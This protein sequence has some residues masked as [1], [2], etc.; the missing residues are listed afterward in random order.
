MTLRSGGIYDIGL[1]PGY[2]KTKRRLQGSRIVRTKH[3]RLFC[4]SDDE[5]EEG[6][7]IL[8]QLPAQW[9]IS[10][11]Q[12]GGF[13]I[14]EQSAE[15][16]PQ[17]RTRWIIDLTGDDQMTD[18]EKED[19]DKPP[20]QR[21][22][23]WSWDFETEEIAMTKDVDGEDVVNSVFDPIEVT[24]PVIIPVLTIERQ[25]N[26]FDPDTIL[27]Y[28]NHVNDATFWGA[29]AGSVLCAG[30][31]ERKGETFNGVEYRAVS[32]VFK[33]RIPNITDVIEG[34][35]L[36]LLDHGPN[37]INQSTGDKEAFTDAEGRK[38]TTNLDASGLP[39]DP[40]D[41]PHILRFKQFKEADFGSLNL[42]WPL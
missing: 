15:R 38:I 28:V 3:W 17:K 31:R 37:A 12:G 13:A 8:G 40:G 1:A 26:G 10:A 9:D 7:D 25:E 34:W 35:K 18:Q 20:D 4:H 42:D 24:T 23:E 41:P 16:D 32:Y 30:I 5:A 33:F 6:E 29:Q 19:K 11:D 27:N 39:I 2:P 22:T 14:R 36:L 21:R